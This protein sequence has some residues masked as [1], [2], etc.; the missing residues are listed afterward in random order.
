MPRRII[1]LLAVADALSI[2]SVLRRSKNLARGRRVLD[3]H[4]TPWQLDLRKG[5]TGVLYAEQSG[6]QKPVNWAFLSCGRVA[7]DYAN[8]LRCVD[9]AKPYCVATR[10]AED[11]PRAEAFRDRHGF[12]KAVGTYAEALL[13]PAVDV[14]YLSSLHSARVEHVTAVLECGKHCVVE[15]P[16][17]CS[18]AEATALV[19]LA[20]SKN[21]FM[22]EGMWT[23]CFPA[24]EHARRLI[25]DGTIGAV[26]A[27]LS[28][29]G[30]DAADSG[31]YPTDTNDTSSGD[32]I[33]FEKLGG[34]ALLWAGPYPI[35]AGLLPFGAAEPRR[36]A[37]AGVVDP[38][39]GVDLSC[40]LNLSYASP[41]GV[42]RPKK[43]GTCPPRGATVSLY[44]SIDAET[45]KTTSYVGQKGRITVLPPAHCPTKLRVELK[46]KGRGNAEVTDF[47]FPFPKPKRPFAPVPG[48]A[49]DEFFHYP[50]SHGFA[51]EA[52]AVTR[53]LNAGL[54]E[55]PQY[56][57]DETLR[58][59]SLVDVAREAMS[60]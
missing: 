51:Y 27:V 10:S 29:F 49:E 8:A 50:N 25:N 56:T 11:L 42:A 44:A 3:D 6:A 17:A 28:D 53:C 32:P 57:L 37:A 20:R 5:S 12:E 16:L 9:G 48:G 40:G 47:E 59:L 35:A 45:S 39:T 24:V 15:K 43:A 31:R 13:D 19:A 38:D 58:A 7:H 4:S 46:G 36:V 60:S 2:T 14:V 21:L 22:M 54:T 55:C 33:Y 34:S 52:A 26:T 41:G 23:R 18:G 30:F 1:A